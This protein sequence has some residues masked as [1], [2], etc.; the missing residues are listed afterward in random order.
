VAPGK[1]ELLFAAR[2][3]RTQA[4]VA[5]WA[6][7]KRYPLA[8]LQRGGGQLDPYPVYEQIRG[9]GPMTL[10]QLGNWVTTRHDLCGRVL[11]DRRFGVRPLGA[12]PAASAPEDFDLSLLDRNPPE[13]TRLR[14]LAAPAFSPRQMADYRPRI[15]STVHRL[16]DDAERQGR[17]DLQ[18]TFSAPLPIAV[19]TDLLG[20]PDADAAALAQHGATIGSALGG[21]TG[22][23]HAARLYKANQALAG[24]MTGVFEL[25]HRE[26]GD[27]VV[28]SL[29]AAGDEIG[30]DELRSLC[31]LLLIAGFETTVNLLGNAVLALLN[32]PEQWN[33]LHDD[34][35]LAARAVEETL[36][37]DPPV[38]RTARVAFEDVELGGYPV[39]KD[40]FVL[41]LIAAANRD[42][43]VYEH[44][45]RFDIMRE[46]PA[47]HLAFSAGIHYCLGAPLARLE[48]TIALQALVE[49]FPRLRQAGRLQYRRS[50]T[51][52]GP[53]VFPVAA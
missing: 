28:S 11:R 23:R 44:P 9:A 29:I 33:A 8:R 25:R 39:R 15:E 17:F 4:L 13:H 7:V 53:Q 30:P 48:A 42:P 49:R 2:L 38:Q 21:I 5:Y 35:T 6:Y 36:R 20:V 31:V 10:S 50:A 37:Y 14:R 52:R 47:E 22:V 16:L 32:H 27:D 12:G 24:L 45:D 26:P 1:Q 46:A 43:D 34:P 51:I 40:Q 19:I 18:S 3:Y 41:T